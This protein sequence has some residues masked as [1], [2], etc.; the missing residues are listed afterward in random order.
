MN[1]IFHVQVISKKMFKN[2][3]KKKKKMQN[4]KKCETHQRM[5]K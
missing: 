3:K 4:I 1:L 5:N 2:V